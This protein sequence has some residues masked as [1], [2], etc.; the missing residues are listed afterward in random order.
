MRDVSQFFRVGVGAVVINDSGKVLALRRIDHSDSWQMPQG[1]INPE[2]TALDSVLREL[3]EETGLRENVILL[4]EHPEWLAYE[5]PEAS[6]SEKT[7]RGQVQK[8]FLF[9]FSGRDAEIQLQGDQGA[10]EFDAFKWTTLTQLTDEV[11]IV[12]KQVY[13]RLLKGFAEHLA[14]QRHDLGTRTS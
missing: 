14:V 10:A 12:K 8:W 3:A 5:L 11:W 2:E 13:E 6:W 4:E 7:G 1:G 9:R